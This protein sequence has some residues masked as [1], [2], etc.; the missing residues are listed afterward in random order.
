M[1][2]AKM[3]AI[4]SREGGGG[5]VGGGG[6]VG[7]IRNF[8]TYINARYLEHFHKIAL[9]PGEFHKTSLMKS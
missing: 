7:L 9:A 5:W 4:L 3:A 1:S 2:S 8:Q 6:G